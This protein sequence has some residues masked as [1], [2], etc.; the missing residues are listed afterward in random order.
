M[1][2][3]AFLVVLATAVGLIVATAGAGPGVGGAGTPV[4]E[5]AAG[6]AA[7]GANPGAATQA[8][9][10]QFD[11]NGWKTN[12]AK[13]SVPLSEI[14]PGGPSKDAIPAIDK[15]VFVT[16]AAADAWLK[17]WEPVILF[18][19]MSDVRAYPLQIL[20]WHEVVNDTVGGIPV[21]VSFCPLCH[22]ANVYDRRVGSMVLDF[23]VTGYLR[24][25][26]L[27]VYD[28][29][30]ESWWQQATG[31][32]LV[33]D[34]SGTLL[35]PLPAQIISWATFKHAFPGGK[36]LSRRTGYQR[37]YGQNPYLGYDDIRASPFL[38][39]GPTDSRL[40]PM[41][42]VV[43]VSIGADSV[44][45]PFSML[46]KTRVVNDTVGGRKIAVFFEHGVASALAPGS[47]ADSRDVGTAGV[48]DRSVG[49][50]I[51]TFAI[52]GG[53]ITDTR[54][55]ST[56]TILGTAAAGPLRG[57]RLKPVLS[58]EQFWFSWAVFRPHT[59]IYRP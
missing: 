29:Q 37:P 56:W 28:R 27:V 49:G 10:P 11:T 13:H 43:T 40:P 48:F 33:G 7:Q 23:G 32:A 55:G 59:R 21:A 47:S 51:L 58:H 53:R 45:Y 2:R 36:A 9:R 50:T 19:R 6:S 54:T 17:P 34:L 25:S 46:E 4:R 24:F 30:T 16:A 44:A 1:T 41:E 52:T 18:A 14:T 20:I 5:A 12:F 26:G 35:R 39:Q 3:S 57:T 8:D 31:Q 38:Y 22:T 42:R 15:P